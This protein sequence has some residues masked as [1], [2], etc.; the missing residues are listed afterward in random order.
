MKKSVQTLFFSLTIVFWTVSA[1]RTGVIDPDLQ[2]LL[3][4]LNPEDEVAVIVTL[5][6]QAD[7]KSIQEQNKSKR[8]FQVTTALKD[9][10]EKTQKSMKD[11]LKVKKARK[12]VPFWIFNGL[13]ATVRAD[14]IDEL[15]AQPGIDTIR[16]DDVIS[17][18]DTLRTPGTPRPDPPQPAWNVAATRAPELW[19]MGYTGTG[20]VVAGMDTGVDGDHPDLAS[21]WRGGSNSWYDPN[22]QHATPHDNA[23]HGTQTMG[24]MVGGGASGEVIGI[25][26]GAR[27]IA[28]KIFDDAGNASF[29]NI[30]LGYQWLLDPDGQSSTDDAPDV[31]NNSWG[32][33]NNVDACIPEFQADIQALKAAQIAVVF[34]AGNEG[35]YPYTSISPA[36]YPESMAVGAV[37]ANLE[38][39]HTSSR[40]PS[41]CDLSLYPQLVAPGVDIITSDLTQG[42]L[43]RIPTPP[44]PAPPFPRRMWRAPWPCS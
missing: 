2:A 34:A 29:S 10:A 22:G 11:F 14:A 18:D 31:V 35:P 23:G 1:A 38:I 44:F 28:V 36:N 21:R 12:V 8:R 33:R 43:S 20:V 25:A 42:G 41:A 26:P 40:G 13:A 6:D 37:D 15:A 17:L 30:H 32:L 3:Y 39:Q 16:L 27:W 19:Y 5:S 9:K 7:L 24:I 4:T